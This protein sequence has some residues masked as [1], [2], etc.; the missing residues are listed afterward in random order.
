M[1]DDP[2]ATFL[3]WARTRCRRR[4]PGRSGGCTTTGSSG[5]KGRR[6]DPSP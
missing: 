2:F 1:T 5:T 3:R 4:A 6:P